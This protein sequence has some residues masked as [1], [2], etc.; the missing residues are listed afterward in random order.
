MWYEAT[1]KEVGP[2]ENS[3]LVHY[4]GWSPKYDEM[5]ELKSGRIAPV[6]KFPVGKPLTKAERKAWDR[7]VRELQEM[8]EEQQKIANQSDTDEEQV[9]AERSVQ[10]ER[11][12]QDEATDL[13]NEVEESEDQPGARE[14]EEISKESAQDEEAPEEQAEEASEKIHENNENQAAENIFP[15]DAGI[16]KKMSENMERSDEAAMD[17]SIPAS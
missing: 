4:K 1:I 7:L 11:E 12:D 13:N 3:V 10:D 15:E 17:S 16:A 14:E 6:G 5:I 2:D 9:S 8:D